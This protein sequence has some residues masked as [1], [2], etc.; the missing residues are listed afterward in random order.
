MILMATC[1]DNISE[2]V[3][4]YAHLKKNS[5]KGTSISIEGVLLQNIH[6][7]DM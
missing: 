1:K 6:H 2:N 4:V 5:I 3:F 7:L